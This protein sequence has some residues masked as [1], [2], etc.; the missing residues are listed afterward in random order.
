MSDFSIQN[1]EII[2]GSSRLVKKEKNFNRIDYSLDNMKHNKAYLE[3][4]KKNNK[5]DKDEII[6][7]KFKKVLNS[8]E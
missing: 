4:L 1:Q 8:T 2:D 5:E 6:L 3:F 7:E